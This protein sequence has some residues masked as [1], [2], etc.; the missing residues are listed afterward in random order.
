LSLKRQD[1][2]ITL[3]GVK[4][5]PRIGVTAEE[6]CNRQECEADVTI[7]GSFEAAAATDC[8]DLSIDYCRM[9]SAIQHAADAREYNLVETLAY[10]IVRDLLQSFPVL[11]VRV[12]L[13]KRPAILSSAVDFIEVEVEGG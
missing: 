1:D 12:K 6:R 7:W 10:R 2:S 13:R 9:L 8:L 5:H 3:S 11:R 4:L